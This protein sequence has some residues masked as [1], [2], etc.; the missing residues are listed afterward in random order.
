MIDS[1]AD[2]KRY[3]GESAA[4]EILATLARAISAK[5]HGFVDEKEV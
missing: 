1:N 4:L 3:C 5:T 2:D